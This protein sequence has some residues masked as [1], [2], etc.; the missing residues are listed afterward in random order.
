MSVKL[1]KKARRSP[2]AARKPG[3]RRTADAQT[4]RMII[5]NIMDPGRKLA[6][7]KKKTRVT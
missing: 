3:G 2:T 7:K 6:Q 5:M 1:K 4:E